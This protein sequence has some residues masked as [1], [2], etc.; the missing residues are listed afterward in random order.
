[1]SGYYHIILMK[2]AAEKQAFMTDKV[3]LIFHSL[4][5]GTNIGPSAFSYILGKV[6]VPY[7]EF[8]LNNL[9]D[10]MIFLTTWQE[11]LQLLNEVLK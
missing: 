11:H 8:A 7:T 6:L 9:D 5:F 2:E 10:I 4:F 3:E 1:M